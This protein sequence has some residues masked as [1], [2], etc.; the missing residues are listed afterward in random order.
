MMEFAVLR[1]FQFAAVLTI[2]IS[3]VASFN[4]TIL[5]TNDVHSHFVEFNTFGGRCSEKLKEHKKCFGGFARQA[6]KV[7]GL[8]IYLFITFFNLS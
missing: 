5:H 6:T 1:I 3:F 4:L 7:R 2:S 8:L